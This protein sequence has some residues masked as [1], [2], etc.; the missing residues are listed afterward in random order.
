VLKVAPLR[1]SAARAA[2]LS[3][4]PMVLP[5]PHAMEDCAFIAIEKPSSIKAKKYLNTCFIYVRVLPMNQ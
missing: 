4:P 1:L 3:L 2:G 5:Q